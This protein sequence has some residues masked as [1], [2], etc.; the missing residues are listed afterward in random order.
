MGGLVA[1]ESSDEEDGT[2]EV[3][4]TETKPQEPTQEAKANTDGKPRTSA[5]DTEEAVISQAPVELQEQQ[6]QQEQ[7]QQPIIG[8]Q[9][10]PE[11]E[12]G[13]SYPPLEEDPTLEEEAAVGPAIPPGSPYSAERATL[14]NLTLPPVPDTEIP[15]SPPGSPPPGT[16][17]KFA[18]FLELKKKGVHFNSKLA[19]SPAL[20]N[21]ALADK[22]LAFVDA[23]SREAQ[24]ATV[25]APDLW[26]P[27]AFP[28]CAF[29]EQLRAAQTETAQARARG[30]GAAV[31]FVPAGEAGSGAGTVNAASEGGVAAA[32]AGTSTGKRKTRFDK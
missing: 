22:L 27:A 32:A 8:P 31:D 10:G 20:Q 19:G 25:L 21:P 14:R 17:R 11:A 3:P 4:V 1:Y 2:P 30:R 23:G 28:R 24:Y 7:Q 29:K 13:P 5:N 9:M 15:P 6:K 18:Q 12:E 16:N 26:D